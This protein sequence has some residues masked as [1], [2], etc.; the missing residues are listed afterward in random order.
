MEIFSSA[1][2]TA[3]DMA[4]AIESITASA[5]T[6]GVAM[7]YTDQE[8]DLLESRIRDFMVVVE[9]HRH[10]HDGDDAKW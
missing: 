10:A 3:D 2:P 4:G 6:S 5:N 9:A 1:Y 7:G 8:V